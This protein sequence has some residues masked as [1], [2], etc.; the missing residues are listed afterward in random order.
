MADCGMRGDSSSR[1]RLRLDRDF[2]RLVLP[3]L[4]GDEIREA[5]GLAQPEFITKS[6]LPPVAELDRCI[7]RRPSPV[8]TMREITR[9]AGWP[10][11]SVVC[12]CHDTLSER[13]SKAPTRVH[14]AEP[15]GFDERVVT[16]ILLARKRLEG[17]RIMKGTDELRGSS[18]WAFGVTLGEPITIVDIT[19]RPFQAWNAAVA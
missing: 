14:F 17:R 19:L 4:S 2:L 11:P 5:L 3:L 9:T 18:I 12:R 16:L 10:L 7:V 15:I 8:V 13:L 6:G 1:D